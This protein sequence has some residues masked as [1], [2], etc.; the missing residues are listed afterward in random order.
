MKKLGIFLVGAAVGFGAMELVISTT[1]PPSAAPLRQR[2]GMAP[3]NNPE[4]SAL[5]SKFGAWLAA[6]HAVAVDDFTAAAGFMDDLKSV[7][8]PGVA[9]TRNLV[10]FLENG[11]IDAAAVRGLIAGRGGAGT[12][13][14]QAWRFAVMTGAAKNGEWA[15]IYKDYKSDRSRRYMPVRLWAAAGAGR[16][17]DALAIV[18]N[19][20]AS[21]SWKSFARG[22]LY[23]ATKNPKTA[24]KH[25]ARVPTGFMN[26]GDYHLVMSFYAK[27]GFVDA[28]AALSREWVGS[29]GGMYMA[30][31]DIKPDWSYYAGFQNMLAFSLI[32]NVSHEGEDFTDSDLLALRAA[33]ALGGNP[34]TTNYYTG[35]YFFWAGSENYK[36]YWGPI[37]PEAAV[38]NPVFAPFIEMKIAETAGNDRDLVRGLER[39]VRGNPLFMPGIVQLWKKNMQNGREYQTLRVLGRALKRPELPDGGRASLLRLRAHTE[40]LFGDLDAAEADLSDAA[41]LAPVDA[42]I[43]ELQARVWAERG[44]N[45]DE[46]YRFAISLI[47]AFP[48][49]ICYWDAMAMVVRAKEGE[50]ETLEIMER[51]G[52][53]AEECSSLFL[54]LG[55]LRA[56]A[57]LFIGAGQAYRKAIELSDDGLV[58]REE[59]ERKLRKLK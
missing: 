20:P 5:D 4:S 19:Y 40:Y 30:G 22:A 8:Y 43:M 1:P 41:Q 32:Q 48:H 36:K 26:L 54:H 12:Q 29:A 52:R 39:L 45:L 50:T 3:W 23:A 16:F 17:N 10:Q 11:I 15:R 44:K 34:D 14:G 35:M 53:V 9:A 55:D 47:K 6:N 42:G 57:G 58:I 33:A 28:A 18:N 27:Y 59:V 51:I 46:A 2:R 37:G 31:V 7:K 56:R 13:A 21:E 25:F 49:N 24:R 38:P